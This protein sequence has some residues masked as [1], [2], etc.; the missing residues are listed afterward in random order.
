M[1]VCV[2]NRHCWRILQARKR[3]PGQAGRH[4]VTTHP[5]LHRLFSEIEFSK[6]TNI[7]DAVVGVQRTG[8]LTIRYKVDR[9]ED[10]VFGQTFNTH[11]IQH[12]ISPGLLNEIHQS[13]EAFASRPFDVDALHLLAHHFE[14]ISFATISQ[15]FTVRDLINVLVLS[16]H[17]E[18]SAFPS[19][20]GEA[21]QR[22]LLASPMM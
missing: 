9:G 2:V 22:W 19:T 3:P 7:K 10:A 1:L 5:L 6:E 13:V 14:R 16:L 21:I 17:A 12:T 11:G 18:D 8:G 15:R 4:P 20:F